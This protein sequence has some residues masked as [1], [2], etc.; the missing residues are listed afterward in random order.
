MTGTGQRSRAPCDRVVVLVLDSCGVGGAPDAALYGD[1]GAATL[2]H[3][4]AACGGLHLPV[5]GKLGLGRVAAV[6]GVPPEASPLGAFGRMVE[7]SAGKDSITGHWE[8]MGVHLLR[9]FPTYPRG[10]P[11]EVIREVE[12]RI[13][14]P[15]LGNRPASGTAI[16]EE[17]GPEHL[18]TARPIVYTS[19]DSVF[20]MAAHEAVI[21][22]QE[23]YRFCRLAREVL[24]GEHGVSRVIARPF[25][26]EPGRFVRTA[27][28]RDFSLPPPEPTVLDRIREAGMPVIGIGK[29]AELFAG[30]GFSA[31]PSTQGDDDGL[32][33]TREALLGISRGFVIAT[34]VDLDTLYGHRNDPRGYG[35]ALERIDAGLGPLLDSLGP[36]DLLLVTADHGTDPTTPG[37][38]HTREAVPLLMAGPPV[39]GGTELG[40]RPT[41]SDLGATVAE[42]LGAAPPRHGTSLL[43]Q[44]LGA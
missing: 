39:R 14:R 18:R 16:I 4:A 3:V 26:G 44:V 27:G 15:V 33:K 24:R 35:A 37:T 38:D 9:P 1:A 40:V 31:A 29:V 10:F 2:P 17:L 34:L 19:A 42:S 25:V 22:P 28:R 6:E 11:P 36:R 21:P 13:G 5:L 41:L 7:V 12:A 30:R 32:R 43:G 23:L 8:L 20:Q